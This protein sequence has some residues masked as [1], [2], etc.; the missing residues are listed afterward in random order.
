MDKVEKKLAAKEEELKANEVELVDQAK[1]LGKTQAE[2]TQLEGELARSRHAILEV[3]ALRAQL[4]AALDQARTAAAVVVYKF[5]ALEQMTKLKDS[6]YNAGFDVGVQAFTYIVM[7][8][9]LDW[10]LS[11]RGE[12]LS[13]LCYVPDFWKI[14]VI[15]ELVVE[16]S[17]YV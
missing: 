16:L 13:A 14:I 4:E 7:T 11:F 12:Q 2:V 17:N 6:S 3:P 1:E 10:D 15:E 9:H 5:L 8:E